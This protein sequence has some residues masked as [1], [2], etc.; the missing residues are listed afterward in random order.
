MR[1]VMKKIFVAFSLA[2]SVIPSVWANEELAR[3]LDCFLCHEIDRKKVGPAFQDVAARYRYYGDPNAAKWLAQTIRTGGRYNWGG[4]SMPGH[5]E[6]S[7]ADA[8]SLA[9]WILSLKTQ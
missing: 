6:V 1:F 8:R 9:E 4:I 3:T 5:P 7:E 2:I